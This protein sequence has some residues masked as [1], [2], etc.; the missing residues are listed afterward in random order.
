MLETRDMLFIL[1]LFF[2]IR[3]ELDVKL[4]E[5]YKAHK[6]NKLIDSFDDDA[7]EH[8]LDPYQRDY[9]EYDKRIERMRDEI[10]LYNKLPS[11]ADEG[12]G[13][14]N[15][16]HQQVTMEMEIEPSVEEEDEQ[17]YQEIAR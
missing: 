1:V 11:N 14:Y 3:Y 2:V 9:D 13:V 16:P 12:A 17:G 4:I 7:V 6:L 5:R 15:L 8:P 10:E